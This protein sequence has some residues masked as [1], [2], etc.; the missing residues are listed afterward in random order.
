MASLYT[1]RVFSGL[2]PALGGATAAPAT[3]QVW[4]VR[5]V[6]W[7]NTAPWYQS[8][9]GFQTLVAGFP[10]FAR[11]DF[12]MGGSTTFDWQGRQELDDTEEIEMIA[13][14]DNWTAVIT[15]YVFTS[16]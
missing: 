6:A 16:P 7:Y 14:D 5:D 9:N 13:N 2:V 12:N 15:A 1:R 11:G 3:G 4:I 8:V 10:F